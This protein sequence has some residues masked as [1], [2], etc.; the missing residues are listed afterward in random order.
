MGIDG[1]EA[2]DKSGKIQGEGEQERKTPHRRLR[3]YNW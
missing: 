2:A 1:N 3:R